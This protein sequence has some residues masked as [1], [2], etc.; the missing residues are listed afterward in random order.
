MNGNN[1]KYFDSFGAAY[2][3]KE[4]EKSIVS[5]NIITDIYSIQ[6]YDSI[7]HDYF[8]LDLSILC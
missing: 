2:T 6:A 5:K 3:P 8:V 4:R 7:I 1:V